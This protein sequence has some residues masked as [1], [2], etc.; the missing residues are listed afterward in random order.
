VRFGLVE[1]R[2]DVA[3]HADED[4]HA[5]RV[6][7]ERHEASVSMKLDPSLAF[8][9]VHNRRRGGDPSGHAPRPCPVP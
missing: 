1:P 3:Q 8:L 9:R 4:R 5:G 6:H 7:G 2:A